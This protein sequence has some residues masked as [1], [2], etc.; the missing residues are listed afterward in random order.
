MAKVCKTKRIVANAKFCA[1][2][3]KTCKR[4]ND[5]KLAFVERKVH[6]AHTGV[7][8]LHHW[9]L[10]APHHSTKQRVES[11][12]Q[13]LCLF[14]QICHHVVAFLQ[15]SGWRVL[16]TTLPKLQFATHLESYN[17]TCTQKKM[18]IENSMPVCWNFCAFA[19]TG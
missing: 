6:F 4:C 5:C 8:F 1:T 2:L 3:N 11:K 10:F 15:L 9:R 19:T 17:C 13:R 16:A 18:G 7:G 14:C 12:E